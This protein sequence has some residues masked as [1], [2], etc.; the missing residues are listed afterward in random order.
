MS[1]NVIT[2]EPDTLLREIATL[3]EHNRIKRVPIMQNGK[4]V[5]LVSR[6]NLVQAL[7]SQREESAVTTPD[8]TALREAVMAN[9]EK[10]SWARAALINVTAHSGTIDLWGLVS[11][12]AEKEAIRVIVEVTPGVG[13]VNDNLVVRPINGGQL[14][15]P[16]NSAT[17][18]GEC[19]MFVETTEATRMGTR[20]RNGWDCQ[21]APSRSGL[22][23]L[24]P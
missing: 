1:R 3:L 9:L 23:K 13:A 4:L 14:E 8:D 12:D 2:A 24:S 6:A 10:E 16:F 19:R 21:L 22:A 20:W 11:S 5:G 17:L 7:A 15:S 18:S